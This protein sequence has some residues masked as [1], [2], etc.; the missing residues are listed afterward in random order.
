MFV[1]TLRAG[2]YPVASIEHLSE[3]ANE[4]GEKVETAR[5]RDGNTEQL[6]EG[7]I[8]R[9]ME[10]SAHPFPAAPDTFVLQQVIDEDDRLSLE[11]VPVLGW[12]VSPKRG[13][14]PITI[15]GINHGSTNAVPVVMPTGEVVVAM[16]CSYLNQECYFAEIR[17]A[18]VG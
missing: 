10:A 11:R 9:I 1:K 5:F 13:V 7:E 18:K 8:E 14:L 6:C 15:D 12:I 17:S 4:S 3:E 2:Y 16:E